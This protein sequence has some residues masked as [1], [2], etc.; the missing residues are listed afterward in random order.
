MIHILLQTLNMEFI[1]V[2]RDHRVPPPLPF[3]PKSGSLNRG[4]SAQSGTTSTSP[5]V[6]PVPRT[7]VTPGGKLYERR[8]P[9]VPKTNT[10]YTQAKRAEYDGNYELALSLYVRAIAENDRAESAIKD[11]AGLLH[12]RGS[13]KEA[14]SFMEERNARFRTCS[15]YQNLL[16]QMKE[17][18]DRVADVGRDLS[19]TILVSIE[20]TGTC[21][22]YI[23]LK[24]L[25]TMFPNSLKITKLV[26]INPHSDRI[27]GNMIAR[28]ERALIEFA[29]HSAARKALMINKHESIKCFWA[30]KDL[31]ERCC[32]LLN[33][34]AAQLVPGGPS[35][36]VKFATVPIQT[37]ESEWPKLLM[38]SNQQPEKNDEYS[39]CTPSV[40]DTSS[41]LSLPIADRRLGSY[42]EDDGKINTGECVCIE[43]CLDTPSPVRHLVSFDI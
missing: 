22:S 42:I 41:P 11:Y 38:G 39:V 1:T 16:K 13:T 17:A 15:G 9:P 35:V 29:S 34:P 24:T 23:E 43:W 31:I 12:M 28:G 6:W 26:F 14:I 36:E 3:H 8:Y 30:P 37:I 10:I 7:S 21:P 5:V 18:L 40:S 4:V 20:E 2:T 25:S 27:S 32:A 19:R 33:R